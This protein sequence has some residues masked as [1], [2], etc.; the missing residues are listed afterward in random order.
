M[1]P[2]TPNLLFFF[3]LSMTLMILI[4]H[5]TGFPCLL[6]DQFKYTL[7]SLVF[8]SG[9]KRKN[10]IFFVVFVFIVF[11]FFL[12][13]TF[14]FSLRQSIKRKILKSQTRVVLEKRRGVRKCLGNGKCCLSPLI[15]R[16]AFR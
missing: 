3:F 6:M 10:K 9:N 7:F 4:C 8:H 14:C 12:L 1:F 15:K 2:T 11:W 13:K 5:H 16:N